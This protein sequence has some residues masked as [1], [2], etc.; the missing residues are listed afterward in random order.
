M[1][2]LLQFQVVVFMKYSEFFNPLK[3]KRLCNKAT[4]LKHF[5]MTCAFINLKL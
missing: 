3:Y 2:E 1:T 5:E 4:A